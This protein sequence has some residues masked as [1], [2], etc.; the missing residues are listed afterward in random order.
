MPTTALP[1]GLGGGGMMGMGFAGGT[2]ANGIA[3]GKYTATIYGLIREQKYA[4][5]ARILSMELQ[6]FPRSRAALSLL[7]YCF[8]QLQDFRSAA[9]VSSKNRIL[10]RVAGQSDAMQG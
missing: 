8:Y 1:T 6:N 2:R 4:D 9:Q 7:A 10:A 3:E 5:A